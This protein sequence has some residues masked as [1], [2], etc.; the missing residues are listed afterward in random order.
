MAVHSGQEAMAQ[1]SSPFSSQSQ[2]KCIIS[3]A[4]SPVT[5][6]E[7]HVSGSTDNHARL[8]GYCMSWSVNGSPV[9]L[10]TQC[11]SFAN[12]V[13]IAEIV[14]L[15]TNMGNLCSCGTKWTAAFFP[16]LFWPWCTSC[17]DYREMISLCVLHADSEIDADKDKDVAWNLAADELGNLVGETVETQLSLI[18][19]NRFA[20]LDAIQK[21]DEQFARS[22]A[23]I[24]PEAWEATGDE[25]EDPFHVVYGPNELFGYNEVDHQFDSVLS[26][27]GDVS[28]VLRTRS[29]V[30]G[31]GMENNQLVIHRAKVPTSVNLHE[32]TRR[33]IF[34]TEQQD[35]KGKKV[36]QEDDDDNLPASPRSVGRSPGRRAKTLP[37]LRESLALKDGDAI[38]QTYDHMG[39]CE[40]GQRVCQICFEAPLTTSPFVSVEGDR[41]LAHFFFLVLLYI[42]ACKS[43]MFWS[44]RQ[45][46]PLSNSF[47]SP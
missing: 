39:D 34:N 6:D 14:Y 1:Q 31:P 20:H 37:F 16:E 32:M 21:H 38:G 2:V 42:C 45:N 43:I 24:P 46:R 10:C 8:S 23:N 28:S 12:S 3:T 36:L 44:V 11:S 27:F 30:G 26:L 19:A 17:S 40:I 18:E 7:A 33:D 9:I 22:I 15:K 35:Q 13:S 25:M 41:T 29:H 47:L 5:V 4:M